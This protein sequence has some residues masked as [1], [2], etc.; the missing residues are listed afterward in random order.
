[1]LDLRS[2]LDKETDRER[3]RRLLADL[4]GEVVGE[5]DEDGAYADLV[6]PT[7]RLLSAVG[8]GT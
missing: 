1:M 4:L 3:T 5:R 6:D 2:A 8:G 7:T